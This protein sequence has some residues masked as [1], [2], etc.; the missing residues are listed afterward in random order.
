[1][2]YIFYAVIS[3]LLLSISDIC[4]K[5]ALNNKINNINYIFW[6]HGVIYLL[7]LILLIC[8][9]YFKPIP[10]LTNTNN[11]LENIK[12]PNKKGIYVLLSGIFGFLALI[13]IIYSFKISKNIGYSVAIIS[14]TCLFTLIFNRIFFDNKI[15][16]IGVIGVISI[17]FGGYLISKCDNEMQLD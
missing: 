12:Y 14:S 8:L 10:L 4:T 3:A 17:L 7:C 5:Y 15:E 1:M 6:S 16:F 2:N 11:I 9:L 13:T